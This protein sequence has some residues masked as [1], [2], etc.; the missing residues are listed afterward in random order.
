[1]DASYYS[2]VKQR[3]HRIPL[4][5]SRFRTSSSRRIARRTHTLL[6]KYLSFSMLLSL[7]VACTNMP[8]ISSRNLVRGKVVSRGLSLSHPKI[9][10]PNF[11]NEIFLHRSWEDAMSIRPE[12]VQILHELLLKVY[13]YVYRVLSRTRPTPLCNPLSEILSETLSQMFS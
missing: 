1:M 12:P 10:Y 7:A 5:L 4:D 8:R 6:S 2:M 9:S 13:H 3:R 11:R